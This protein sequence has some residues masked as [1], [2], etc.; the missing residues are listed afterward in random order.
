MKNIFYSLLFLLP[1]S[2]LAQPLTLDKC[3]EMALEN[4]FN[5]KNSELN[6]DISKDTYKAYRSNFYPNISASASYLYSTMSFSES[7]T[8]GYLPTF[9]PDLT[10]G[11]MTPNVIGYSSDGTPIFSSY[12]Y[13]PD[14]D[15]DFEVGSV[16]SAGL[17][18]SQ[19]IYMGGKVS[20]AT[21]LAKLGIATAQIQ[22]NLTK[23]EVI[24]KTDEA[25]YTYLKVNEMQQSADAFREVVDELY[26]MVNDML[27]N[28][29]CTQNEL[30]KVQIKVGEAELNQL[31]AKNARALSRMN[32]CYMLGMSITT[33]E[34]EVVDNFNLTPELDPSLDVS[35]RAE[36]SLLDKNIEAK[37]LELKLSKS[38]FIPQISAMASYN[39][40]NGLSINNQ[41]MLGSSP[42]FTGGVVVSIPIFHASE[43]RHKASAARHRIAIAENTKKDLVHQMTLELKQAIN[44]VSES[45]AELKL[46]ERTEQSAKENLRQ[47]GEQYTHGM[48]TL[49]EVLE[50]QALWQKSMS[51]V[52]ES[53]ANVRLAYLNYQR[54][55][56]I[57]M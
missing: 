6:L 34:L 2:C 48:C 12:A 13:M 47:M 8:G 17:I 50:A 40:T 7:I 9:T 44:T 15:F 32:L 3:R 39:Y 35:S 54:A 31:K 55:K 51:D 21:K 22:Q 16:F 20:T 5:V 49:S 36:Y 11:T 27:G 41:T 19:P 42:S 43:T 26:R 25:F 10:T 37:G 1:F 18:A 56:G 28:G 57:D 33:S 38:D 52:I 30:L 46:M 45:T 29:L 4:S 14:I 53:R 24:I 23:T